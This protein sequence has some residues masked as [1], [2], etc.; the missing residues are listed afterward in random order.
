MRPQQPRSATMPIDYDTP[1]WTL[2]E[3]AVAAGYE[4]NTLRSYYSPH[5]KLFRIIGGAEAQAKGL[6]GLLNLRDVLQLAVAQRLIEIGV[7]PGDAF[8]AGVD[9]AHTSTTPSG[10]PTRDPAELFDPRE[11]FTFLIWMPGRGGEV[12]PVK[13]SDPRLDVVHLIYNQ[14]SGRRGPA[15]VILLNDV[16]NDV[17]AA[18]RIARPD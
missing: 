6:A 11:A 4:P 13:T 10:W 3:A 7:H 1:K 18:L 8:Q 15:I 16:Q 14:A 12:V 5:R 17:F 9:F 2:R